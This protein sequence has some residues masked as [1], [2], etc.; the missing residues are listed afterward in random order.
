[1]LLLGLADSVGDKPLCHVVDFAVDSDEEDGRQRRL[2]GWLRIP[3]RRGDHAAR[4]DKDAKPSAPHDHDAHSSS[5]S[6]RGG[7]TDRGHD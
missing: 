2:A 7:P 6:T 4:D 3:P 1:M 5:G